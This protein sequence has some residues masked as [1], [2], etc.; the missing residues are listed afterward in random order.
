MQVGGPGGE[1]RGAKLKLKLLADDAAKVGDLQRQLSAREAELAS[2]KSALEASEA[3]LKPKVRECD[4]LRFGLGSA[5]VAVDRGRG[6]YMIS[7]SGCA[8]GKLRRCTLRWSVT[9][10]D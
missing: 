4:K 7:P 2:T 8:P 1:S 3:N 10:L 9:E 6:S 5:L